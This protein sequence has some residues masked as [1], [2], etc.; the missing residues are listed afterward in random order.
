MNRAYLQ[1]C[2]CLVA[3]EC[4]GSSLSGCESHGPSGHSAAA[5]HKNDLGAPVDGG[6]SESAGAEAPD[7]SAKWLPLAPTELF[8]GRTLDEWAIEWVRWTYSATSC[9]S[10]A[11]DEDGSKCGLYQPANAPLFFFDNGPP[12]TTRTLC[13]VP[14]GEAILVPLVPFSIDNAGVAPAETLDDTD[15]ERTASEVKASMRDLRLRVDGA[16]V[17]GLTDWGI[18]PTEFDYVLPSAPNWYSC[19]GYTGIE[20]K[21]APAF[22]AGFFVLLPPP[23]AGSH[24][25]E[26]AGALTYMG[27]QASV[28][29]TTFTVE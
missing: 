27:E 6:A 24:S 4:L 28:V 20:G 26:Y 11:L 8:S 3:S 2:A 22:V 10:T 19:N 16:D 18:G 9:D 17:A 5:I 29:K 15:L 25:L 1:F 7:S 14:A 13:V 21:I 23:A 12:V